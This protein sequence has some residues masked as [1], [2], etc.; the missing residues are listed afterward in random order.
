MP[1]YVLGIAAEILGH[2]PGFQTDV[3]VTGDIEAPALAKL[4]FALNNRLTDV[5][6]QRFARLIIEHGH[7]RD[8]DG[9]YRFQRKALFWEVRK[10]TAKYRHRRKRRRKQENRQGPQQGPEQGSP[11]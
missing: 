8:R 6:A 7:R 9:T 2:V 3:G 5:H 10:P 1:G 4:L 11:S